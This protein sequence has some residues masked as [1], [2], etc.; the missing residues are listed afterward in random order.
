MDKRELEL[1]WVLRLPFC[2]WYAHSAHGWQKRTPDVGLMFETKHFV[3]RRCGYLSGQNQQ[4]VSDTWVRHVSYYGL[5]R[6]SFR[7]AR[8][9]GW[10]QGSTY[11]FHKVFRAR[12]WSP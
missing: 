8:K 2:A 12:Y 11:C 10:C 4:R 6:P 7:L 5:A 1:L 9:A 3:I